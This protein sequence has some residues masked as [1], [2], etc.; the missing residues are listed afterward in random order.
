[1]NELYLYKKLRFIMFCPV[2]FCPVLLPS[3]TGTIKDNGNG[4]GQNKRDICPL[5]LLSCPLS[6]LFHMV[7]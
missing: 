4:K 6:L 7:V 1:M 3:F 2:P 5:P